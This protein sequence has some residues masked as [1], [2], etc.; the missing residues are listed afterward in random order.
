MTVPKYVQAADAVRAQIEDGTLKPGGPA[1]SGA[2]LARLTGFSTLTCRKALSLLVGSGVLVPGPS[3][4]ARSRVAGGDPDTAGRL[5]AALAARR[6][7]AGLKQDEFAAI[8]GYSLTAVSHAET[9]RLW[10]TMTTWGLPTAVHL[11]SVVLHCP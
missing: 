1:P 2:A 10:R 4:N 3:P 6:R 5:S 9:G 11:S 8:I 7:A